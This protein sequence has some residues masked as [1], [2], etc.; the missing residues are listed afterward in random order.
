MKS[1]YISEK[2]TKHGHAKTT[3]KTASPTYSSWSSMLN[4]CDNENNT[5]YKNYGGKG[6]L[7]CERWRTFSHFLE[8]M[9]EKPLKGMSIERINNN[10]NYEKSNCKWACATEQNRNKNGVI[11]S[12]SHVK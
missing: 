11:L 10:G 7:V 5:S 2:L 1:S 8:D 3:D 12:I 6:I 9:G 4:R